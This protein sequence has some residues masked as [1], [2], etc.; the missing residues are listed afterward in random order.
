MDRRDHII[1]TRE[2][3]SIY[4]SID[5]MGRR[6]AASHMTGKVAEIDGNRIRV[7]LLPEGANGQPFLSPWVQAQEAAGGTAT[8]FPWAV[9]DP[10][11]LFSP[12]G[13]LGPQSIAIRDSYT[14]GAP[15]PTDDEQELVVT[16]GG[17]TIRMKDG[18]MRLSA[19]AIWLEG[20]IRIKG[21]VAIEGGGLT[22]NGKNVGGDHRHKG[23]ERGGATT[24]E[25][26]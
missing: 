6:L 20:D 24:D 15:A 8:H 2:L 5:D 14:D 10:V 18:E 9:G 22:H 1:L 25:P 23:V 21:A 26:V 17:G 12:Q 3:R 4:K 11:R 7:E 19:D 13:E 16:Y